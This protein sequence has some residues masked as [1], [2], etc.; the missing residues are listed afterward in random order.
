MKYAAIDAVH[1]PTTSVN[2]AFK[3]FAK[4]VKLNGIYYF[5][6]KKTVN[7]NIYTNINSSTKGTS[8][9]IHQSNKEEN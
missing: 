6:K 2:N 7:N 3:H 1:Q 8:I 9:H 5:L 4:R